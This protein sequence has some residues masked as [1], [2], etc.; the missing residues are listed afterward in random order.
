MPAGIS[1]NFTGVLWHTS[2]K[3]DYVNV[4]RGTAS[5]N[6]S[7]PAGDNS[8]PASD[9]ISVALDRVGASHASA[10]FRR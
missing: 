10:A 6:I 2:D 4:A 9:N 1:R 3:N 5:D 8:S 7:S